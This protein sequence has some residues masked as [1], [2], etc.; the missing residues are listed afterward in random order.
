MKIVS[1]EMQL[2]SQHNKRVEETERERLRVWIDSP[3]NPSRQPAEQGAAR[4]VG[5]DQVQLSPKA[6]Q[7]QPVKHHARLDE[8]IGPLADTKMQA[9]VR[10]VERLTGKKIEFFDP[11]K[12]QQ[13]VDEV[14][15]LESPTE[16]QPSRGGRTGFGVEYDYYAARVEEEHTQFEAKGV[17]RTADGQEINIDLS[18]SMSRRF[19]EEQSIS[20]RAGDAQQRLKDPLVLNFDGTA[21]ELS[22]TK[23]SFD[24]DSDGR[25]DQIALLSGDSGFLAL[26]KNGDGKI[27]DGSEL[28]GAQSGNGFADLAA[29]DQDGN[30]WIDENDAIYSKLRIWTRDASGDDQ[31]FALGQ[32]DVGA[33]YLGNVSSQFDLTDSDNRLQGQVAS[34][35]VFL[36]D[37]GG[38][39]T[40]QQL[41]LVV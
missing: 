12:L 21:A 29:Y 10:L 32:K 6:K 16:A 20:I 26:D 28:F 35:G 18:L 1:S 37:S 27:N 17:V 15:Q 7:I 5:N 11:K 34:S 22:E 39:G 25:E 19:M 23:F 13:A 4:F 2:S 33:I 30:H 3:G 24:L 8:E 41:N 40:V 9:L 38:A 14:D 31:L 36:K